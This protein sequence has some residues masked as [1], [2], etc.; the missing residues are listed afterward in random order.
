MIVGT[1]DRQ[2][3]IAALAW[4]KRYLECTDFMSSESRGVVLHIEDDPSVRKA[5]EMLVSGEGYSISSVSGGPH[6]IGLVAAG[7]R[8][9]LLIVDFHLDSEMN[10]AEATEEVRRSLGYAPPV[11]MLTGDPASAEFPWITDA[12]VWLARKPLSP[13]FLLA[14]LPG[15]VTLSRATRGLQASSR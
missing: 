3:R 7:L 10:G 14:A 1:T 15:L 11:I 12:P 8:P 4:R 6:A 5:M 13:R 2:E 9:D